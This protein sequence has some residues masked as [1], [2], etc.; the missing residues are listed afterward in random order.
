MIDVVIR[1]ENVTG[2]G[3]RP[4][5]PAEAARFADTITNHVAGVITRMAYTADRVAA[6]AQAV[7][8][9]KVADRRLD[10]SLAAQVDAAR[11]RAWHEDD[12][13]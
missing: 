6:D 8:L 7:P 4:L 10:P 5:E 1:L 3:D 11:R 9:D 12:R 2:A 13:L